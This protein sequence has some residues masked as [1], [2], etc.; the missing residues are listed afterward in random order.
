MFIFKLKAVVY[1]FYQYTHDFDYHFLLLFALMP[2][3]DELNKSS[4]VP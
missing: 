2:F 1:I 3:Q 4:K